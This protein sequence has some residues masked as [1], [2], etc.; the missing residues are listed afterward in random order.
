LGLSATGIAQMV[1]IVDQF[2]GRCGARQVQRAKIGLTENGG[3]FLAR[4]AAAISVHI[5]SA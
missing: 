3:G 1:E 2:R 5:F 4:D